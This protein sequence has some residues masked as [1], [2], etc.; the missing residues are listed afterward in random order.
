MALVCCEPSTQPGRRSAAC[1]CPQP[2]PFRS[3]LRRSRLG[4][5][6]LLRRQPGLFRRARQARLPAAGDLSAREP[7]LGLPVVRDGDLPGPGRAQ[8]RVDPPPPFLTGPTRPPRR[9]ERPETIKQTIGDAKL[10]DQ[11]NQREFPTQALWLSPEL[12][13]RRYQRPSQNLDMP[14]GD[15]QRDL[16]DEAAG[17][18]S[19]I[20]R[21]VSAAPVGPGRRGR[22]PPL[23]RSPPSP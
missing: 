10:M 19:M 16:R 7:I 4:P 5:G 9:V 22:P 14:S 6:S 11:G 20:G 8:L 18:P 15:C 2:E 23:A 12:R 1:P 21:Q 13:P 3:H 17:T